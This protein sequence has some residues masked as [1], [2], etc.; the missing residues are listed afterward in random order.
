MIHAYNSFFYFVSLL[1]LT[2]QLLH[3]SGKVF[4]QVVASVFFSFRVNDVEEAGRNLTGLQIALDAGC[5]ALIVI[6]RVM[7]AVV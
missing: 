3:D 2:F 7:W 6:A 1:S 4:S 5:A